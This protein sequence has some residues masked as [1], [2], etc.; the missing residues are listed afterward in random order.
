M[1]RSTRTNPIQRP[2]LVLTAVAILS[3][4]VYS[5][6]FSVPFVFD[7]VLTIVEN[8]FVR[9]LSLSADSGRAVLSTEHGVLR[10]LVSLRPI[11]NLTF[12]LNYALHGFEL[13]GY[14]LV[15]LIIHIVNAFL[16][17][18]LVRFSFGTPRMKD[19]LPEALPGMAGFFA[20]ILFAVHP[21]Q[22]Q[23]VTYIVQRY[24]S[25]AAFFYLLSLVTYMQWRRGV[26]MTDDR[27]QMAEDRQKRT[28]NRQQTTEDRWKTV[29][30]K[31]AIWYL[32]SIISA[33]LAMKTKE[34]AFTLPL[35]IALYEFLFF[36]G[37]TRKRVLFLL[38]LL[39]TMPLIPLTLAGI[40]RPYAGLAGNVNDLEKVLT[41]MSPWDYLLT[42][43]RV[44]VTYVRLLIVPVNQNLDYD[45]PVYHSLFIPEVFFSFLFLLSFFV[46]G[47]YLLYRA[48]TGNPALRLISFGIFWFFIT[49]S[50]ESS[51][52]PIRDVI[53][54]HRVYLPSVGFFLAVTVSVF[55]IANGLRTAWRT[56][57][58][59]A[60]A[61]LFAL[62]LLLA[63]AAYSRN[64]VWHDEETLWADVV[65]K[66]PNKAR[67]YVNLGSA[68]GKKGEFHRAIETLSTAID[69]DPN[70]AFAY[71]NRGMAHFYAGEHQ[72]AFDDLTRAI[73]LYR[74]SVKT[75]YHRAM[76]SY[77]LGNA[78]QAVQ[79]LTKAVELDPG[80][81][82][83]Y[84]DRGVLY[85]RS[86]NTGAA[87]ADHQQACAMG[88]ESSCEAVRSLRGPR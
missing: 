42:Q 10:V 55:L 19:P 26:R 82:D 35:V 78:G 76:V 53:F 24:A 43:F 36:D 29:K 25:L 74:F 71:S 83:A 3:G 40:D 69:L 17:Y 88:L 16:V 85:A 46:L 34:I 6:T 32:A 56:A 77:S 18:L 54:E 70:A 51:L 9:D 38:P 33:I 84:H 2:L 30:I 21:V 62:V 57:V 48:R 47:V 64:R 14:H 15:N 22:T 67:G 8:P 44:I 11:G 4:L 87:V 1:I 72:P 52:L 75:Y 63:G 66:S 28:D 27:G 31:P 81:A 65:K 37:E 41:I 12:A 20:A 7:D 45:Y 5:N 23:A 61:V 58:T 59:A 73:E 49:L 13:W 60:V 68:Y 86:G 80:F 39:L 50:V 79:D